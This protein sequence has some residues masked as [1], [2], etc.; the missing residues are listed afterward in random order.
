M[1]NLAAQSGAKRIQFPWRR[2]GRTI[3]L[4]LGV[5]W[6]M[7]A[8]VAL[9]VVSALGLV[10]LFPMMKEGTSLGEL[11]LLLSG[12]GFFV[13]LGALWWLARGRSLRKAAVAWAILTVP[14]LTY[15]AL[16]GSR[17]TAY[18][19]GLRLAKDVAIETFSEAPIH[20]PGFDGPVGLSI[21]FQLVHPDGISALIL[22]PEI[23]MGPAIEVPHDVLSVSH[24]GGSGYF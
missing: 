19:D 20:W 14:C 18:F 2:N 22:P 7:L 24:T 12:M 4:N 5:I 23:R 16:A 21:Q 17:I 1:T 10:F 8:Y 6:E 9:V 13:L 11:P 3:S 15:A